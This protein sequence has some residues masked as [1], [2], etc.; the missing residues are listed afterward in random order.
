[1]TQVD[2]HRSPTRRKTSLKSSGDQ[3]GRLLASAKT[4]SKSREEAQRKSAGFEPRVLTGIVTQLSPGRLQLLVTKVDLGHIR[5]GSSQLFTFNEKT[6]FTHDYGCWLDKQGAIE[7]GQEVQLKAVGRLASVICLRS[8]AIRGL[9]VQVTGH[10]NQVTVELTHIGGLSVQALSGF[11][12][13]IEVQCQDA[14]P[15]S[16]KIG[17]SIESSGHF[18]TGAGPAFVLDK[19]VVVKRAEEFEAES[20]LLVSAKP[21]QL[22]AHGRLIGRGEPSKMSVAIVLSPTVSIIVKRGDMLLQL[23]EQAFCENFKEH[24]L[25]SIDIDGEYD[26]ES[27]T[28]IAKLVIINN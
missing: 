19:E 17:Q 7:I 16:L 9:A 18:R 14:L 10:K 25:N 4:L 12:N 21:L 1:M 13:L 5:E 8:T 2:Q 11:D 24:Q 27:R 15:P 26:S 22:L 3:D 20:I 28:F 6:Q 23:S